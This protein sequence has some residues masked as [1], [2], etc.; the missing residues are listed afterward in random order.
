MDTLEINGKKPTKEQKCILKTINDGNDCV[1]DSVPGG[2]KST[3][4]YFIAKLFSTLQILNLTFSKDL[5]E[6]S[7]KKIKDLHLDNMDIESYNSF[8]HNYYG[9]GGMNTEELYQIVNENVPAI[10]KKKI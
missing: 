4:C 3:T 2:G 8:A 9:M 7:R 6:E 5:K 1:S 10:K